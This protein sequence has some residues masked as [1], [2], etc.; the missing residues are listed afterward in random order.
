MPAN[1]EPPKFRLRCRYGK[2]GRLR[3]LGHLDLLRTLER[4]VRRAGLPFAVSQGFSPRMKVAYGSA[5]PVG[6]SSDV[7]WLDLT[8]TEPVPAADALGR[9][10][11][12]TEP[13]VPFFEAAYVPNRLPALA[14][15]LDR[16]RWEVS[17]S[18][19]VEREA[20]E[21]ALSAIETEGSFRFLR[22]TKERTCDVTRTLVGWELASTPEG[23][24]LVLDTRSSN[25]GALRP[26][27]LVVAAY[28]RPGLAAGAVPDFSVARLGQWHEERD[29]SLTGA[30]DV[31]PAASAFRERAGTA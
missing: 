7:E 8:L 31:A 22:G 18:D 20:L 6:A 29:G 19:P 15:W 2:T 13:E 12:A 3:Y 16:A 21:G 25:E 14:A 17:F 1:I 28:T 24:S 23:A 10:Q 30:M 9:L 4:T 5:L 26:D 27:T 11:E